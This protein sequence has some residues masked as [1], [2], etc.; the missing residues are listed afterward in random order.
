MKTK[1]IFIFL[2]TLSALGNQAMADVMCTTNTV[3]NNREA[4]CTSMT[5]PEKSA[6]S[7][8]VTCKQFKITIQCNLYANPNTLSLSIVGPHGTAVSTTT[9]SELKLVDANGNGAS[10]YCQ[11]L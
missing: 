7:T 5:I 6:I 8:N 3:T 2:S 1:T 4:P 10:V 9:K 11:A